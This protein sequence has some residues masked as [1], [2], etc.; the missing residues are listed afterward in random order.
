M[1]KRTIWCGNSYYDYFTVLGPPVM[2]WTIPT[3]SLEFCFVSW[4]V[5]FD[6]LFCVLAKWRIPRSNHLPISPW[7]LHPCRLGFQHMWFQPLLVLLSLSKMPCFFLCQP[8][9]TNFFSKHSSNASPSRDPSMISFPI[10]I[11]L[12]I[13]CTFCA[14]LVISSFAVLDLFPLTCIPSS[15][16]DYSS[17]RQLALEEMLCQLAHRRTSIIIFWFYNDTIHCKL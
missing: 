7:T 4:V 2:W 6:F 14:V 3:V 11:S 16:L 13:V 1:L 10:I 17:W 5:C 9:P 8:N 12:I 15:Q